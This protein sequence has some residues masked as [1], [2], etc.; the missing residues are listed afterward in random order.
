MFGSIL[1]TL[2]ILVS[3]KVRKNAKINEQFHISLEFVFE[4]IED[5]EELFIS[6][7]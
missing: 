6:I 1:T 4:E 2:F 5:M 7:S 3:D